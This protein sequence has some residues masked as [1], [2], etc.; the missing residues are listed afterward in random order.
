MQYNHGQPWTTME[1]SGTRRHPTSG[2]GRFRVSS[3]GASFPS[4]SSTSQLNDFS[5]FEETGWES[6]EKYLTSRE[7]AAE[8]AHLSL[9]PGLV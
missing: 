7:C 4:A 6:L 9:H 3:A 8:N 2:A 5:M 1:I